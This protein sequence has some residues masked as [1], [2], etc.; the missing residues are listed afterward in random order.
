[1][2]FG[3]GL[4]LFRMAAFAAAQ[5]VPI[6]SNRQM[7]RVLL[8]GSAIG[9]WQGRMRQPR[10]VDPWFWASP[11][12][13]RAQVRMLLQSSSMPRPVNVTTCQLTPRTAEPCQSS[14]DSATGWRTSVFCSSAG[15]TQCCGG[16][17]GRAR[18]RGLPDRGVGLGRRR[19]R[20]RH[21]RCTFEGRS[22]GCVHTST[23]V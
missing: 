6:A 5:Q 3:S 23:R 10:R 11:S 7:L 14:R 2:G 16:P 22:P 1:M 4:L 8:Q 19:A 12:Q 18:G 17:G 15:S 13:R 21:C 20:H 9:T